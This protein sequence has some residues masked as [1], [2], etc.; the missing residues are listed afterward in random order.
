MR[1]HNFTLYFIYIITDSCFFFFFFFF[2]VWVEGVFVSVFYLL[3]AVLLSWCLLS[4]L[5]VFRFVLFVFLFLLV[6]VLCQLLV[7][8]FFVLSS[9]CVLCFVFVF[10]SHV[11][12][13]YQWDNFIIRDNHVRNPV[14]CPQLLWTWSWELSYIHARVFQRDSFLGVLN[15]PIT[16]N[17]WCYLYI[18]FLP[19]S[20]R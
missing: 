10:F 19:F 20:T 16:I 9:V 14:H 4:C 17:Q 8:S 12:R 6:F 2:N 13:I 11:A 15:H 3:F 1:H 5:F 18:L 7:S